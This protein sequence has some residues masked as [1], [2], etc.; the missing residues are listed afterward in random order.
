MKILDSFGARP[1]E[2]DLYIQ[3]NKECESTE[4][5]IDLINHRD[6]LGIEYAYL[7]QQLD[8]LYRNKNAKLMALYDKVYTLCENYDVFIV[9]HENVYHPDFIKK[10][11]NITYTVLYTSDDPESSYKATVPYVWA[12][13]HVLCYAVYYSENELMS[14]KICDWNGRRANIRPYGA[15]SYTYDS[16]LSKDALFNLK[17]DIDLIYVGG[18]YNKIENLMKLKQVFGKRF[19]LFGYW[20]GLIPLLSRFRKYGQL[21]NITALDQDMFITIY[22]RAKIGI[23]MHMSYGPSNLRMWQLPAN[24]VMQICD[25]PKGTSHLFELDRE[26]VCY[27]NGSIDEAIEKIQYYLS[28]DD[29]RIKI[30]KL[31]YERTMN[32]YTY[33]KTFQKAINAIKMGIKDKNDKK[34]SNL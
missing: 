14:D 19:Q 13:D 29:E 2:V 9:N 8:D 25:N 27:E 4:Y 34:H 3:T 23:N 28:H 5:T 16:K 21:V 7:P 24:G 20:G 31:G 1:N 17:R 22:Q 18:P 10:L 11:S 33:S 15:A 6:E 32:D 26:I 12:F 30:A